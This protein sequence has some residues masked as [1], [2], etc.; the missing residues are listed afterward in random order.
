MLRK[1]EWSHIIKY[2]RIEKGN[3]IQ[4]LSGWEQGLDSGGG[5]SQELDEAGSS[6]LLFSPGPAVASR[7]HCRNC[8]E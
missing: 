7:C 6:C 1:P 4:S 5:K 8:K 3:L 2:N